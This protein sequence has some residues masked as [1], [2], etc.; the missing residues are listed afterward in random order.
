MGLG[1]LIAGGRR[2]NLLARGTV[3]VSSA[4]D[5]TPAANLYDGDPST[6]FSFDARAT[7]AIIVDSD[8]TLGTG[9]FE[10]AHVSGAPPG[11]TAAGGTLTRDTVF[12]ASGTSSCRVTTIGLSNLG[13]LQ[14]DFAC[15]AGERL[16]LD[17]KMA[18][19]GSAYVR[20]VETGQFLTDEGEWTDTLTPILSVIDDEEFVRLAL[21]FDVSSILYYE[22][23]GRRLRF[24]A[25]SNSAGSE[26]W[27]DDFALYPVPNILGVFGHGIRRNNPLLWQ[28][29]PTLADL[30]TI[31]SH[32]PHRGTFYISRPVSSVSED[33]KLSDRYH[34]IYLPGDNV[35][36][37]WFGEIVLARAVRLGCA[38]TPVQTTHQDHRGSIPRALG[39]EF[40]YALAASP[41]RTK[42]FVF[43][44]PDTPATAESG[45]W[46]EFWGEFV[47]RPMGGT[48]VLLVPNDDREEVLYGTLSPSV[49]ETDGSPGQAGYK[50]VDGVKLEELPLP[51][52]V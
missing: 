29:A 17:F 43:Q 28:T 13:T 51:V 46:Q 35:E 2:S 27:V 6:P 14:K 15:H 31:A 7:N 8:L 49:S 1:L 33:D 42:Q 20:D 12:F 47:L 19:F 30:T 38:M 16:V 9:T 52:E 23:A 50:K 3:I 22:R 48:P 21:E 25:V 4:A 32:A 39:G 41:R 26:V 5:E 24:E 37:P 34:R 11:W 40:S 45:Y 36:P 44:H 18:G 10:A